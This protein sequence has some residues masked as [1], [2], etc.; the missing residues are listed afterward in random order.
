M[1]T[2]DNIDELLELVKKAK[3]QYEVLLVDYQECAEEQKI[4]LDN[5]IKYSELYY[6]YLGKDNDY[7]YLLKR[8]LYLLWLKIK[9]VDWNLTNPFI[10]KD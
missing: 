10:V 6:E 5:W 7:I 4:A 8:G 2:S 1:V 9:I 3:K